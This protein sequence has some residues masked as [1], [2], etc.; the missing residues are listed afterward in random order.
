MALT[1]NPLSTPSIEANNVNHYRF[2]Q[3]ESFSFKQS[4]QQGTEQL[5]HDYSRES[6]AYSVNLGSQQS[7]QSLTYSQIKYESA[8]SYRV[9]GVNNDAIT[10]ADSASLETSPLLEG[11]SNIVNFIEARIA[12]EAGE[13]A[14]ASE[15]ATLIDQGLS[16]FIQGYGEAEAI[17]SRTGQLN[18]ITQGAIETLYQQVVEGFDALKERYTD[19]ATS[20]PAIAESINNESSALSPFTPQSSVNTSAV[21]RFMFSSDTASN[22]PQS[23]AGSDRY[24]L[25]GDSQISTISRSILDLLEQE[26]VSQ[27][28]SNKED[29]EPV[30]LNNDQAQ[31]I[32]A[33]VEYG[34]KDRFQFELTTLDGDTISIN[35]SNTLAFYGEYG[36]DSEFAGSEL[37]Q[38]ATQKNRF[39]ME[40]NGELDD[41]ERAAIDQL[42]GQVMNLAD[43]F[44]NGDINKA[45]AA[46]LDLGY[47]QSEIATYAIR[48]QQLEQVSVTTAYSGLAPGPAT[49]ASPAA[50]IL[51]RISDYARDIIDSLQNPENYA[52]FEYSQLLSILSKQIDQQ[53]DSKNTA[54]FASAVDGIVQGLTEPLLT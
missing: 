26:A 44:Y 42:L 8:T 53:I 41:G 48:L 1:F 14:S 33:A 49:T 13:G 24:P 32:A 16:G 18:A 20:Q 9:S 7:D 43:E 54:G 6:S 38:G 21:T 28:A 50:D 27:Q 37:L 17:L 36:A 3:K 29:Q 23:S 45:Y 30:A 12:K 4:S 25:V 2:S 22:F 39:A 5:R 34:R 19:Q 46:A 47:D 10:K 51:S 52:L 40:V 15:L 11:A 31:T 35:A